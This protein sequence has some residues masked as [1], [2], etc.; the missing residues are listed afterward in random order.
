MNICTVWQACPPRH[1]CLRDERKTLTEPLR[2]GEVFLRGRAAGR[3]SLE[4]DDDDDDAKEESRQRV[5]GSKGLGL[6]QGG[7][8]VEAHS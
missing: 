7:P 4:H 2:L 3:G 8:E 1:D 5:A 6:G